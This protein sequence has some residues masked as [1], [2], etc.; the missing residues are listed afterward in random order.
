MSI[1]LAKFSEAYFLDRT[2]MLDPCTPRG[3]FAEF[4][5]KFAFWNIMFKPNK[6]SRTRSEKIKITRLGFYNV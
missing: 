3:H 6:I 5:Q 2:G 4:Q 1:V